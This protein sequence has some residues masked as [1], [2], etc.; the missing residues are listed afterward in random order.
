[1][2]LE[3]TSTTE[4]EIFITATIRM[5][6][7]GL[8]FFNFRPSGEKFAEFKIEQKLVREAGMQINAPFELYAC[9]IPSQVL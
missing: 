2:L 3:N 9:D 8:W 7:L 4:H 6:K 1:M 5:S